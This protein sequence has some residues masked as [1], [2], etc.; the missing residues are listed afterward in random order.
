VTLELFASDERIEGRLHA[1]HR[2]EPVP[3]SGVLGLLHAIEDLELEPPPAAEPVE[4]QPR[5]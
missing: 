2:P 1:S 5:R 3:F 4:Q